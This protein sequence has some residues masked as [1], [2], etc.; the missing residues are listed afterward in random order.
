VTSEP[1]RTRPG[2]GGSRSKMINK[3]RMAAER[4]DAKELSWWR[5][6]FVCRL[7]NPPPIGRQLYA[8]RYA[9]CER[10]EHGNLVE[11]SWN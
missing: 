8:A 3:L 10:N 7:I 9:I 1:E 2:G 6:E 4:A 5:Q 11:V